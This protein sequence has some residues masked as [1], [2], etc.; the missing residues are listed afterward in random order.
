MSI[1]R[2][3][4]VLVAALGGFAVSAAPITGGSA[5]DDGSVVAIAQSSTVICSGA[6]IAP[7]AVLTAA[8]CL[9]DARLPDVVEGPVPATGVHHRVVGAFVHPDYNPDT[10]DHDLAVVVVEDVL[11]GAPLPYASTLPAAA[12]PGAIVRVVGYGRT[13]ANDPEPPVQHAGTSRIDAV[14]ALRIQSSAAAPHAGGGGAGRRRRDAAHARRSQPRAAPSPGAE[15]DSGGPALIDDGGILRIIGVASTGD[16]AC[17]QFAR[18]TRVDVHAAFVADVVAKTTAGGAAPGDRCWYDANCATGGCVAAIDEPR[19]SFC[20]P[21]CIDGACP[22]GL[23]CSVENGEALCRHPWPSPGADRHACGSNAD[24]ASELCLAAA[25][26]EQ[27]VCTDRCFSDLPGFACPINTECRAAA[28]GTEG[29][30]AIDAGGGCDVAPGRDRGAL[31]VVGLAG[32]VLLLRRR[33]HD[34][35]IDPPD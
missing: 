5:S 33:R 21:A 30:F 34:A 20:S 23:A 2:R 14:D 6:I 16:V 13:V 9:S 8:H 11:A 7:H 28:D 29:C 1:L 17:T 26:E 25:G 35:A 15:G 3:A 22:S 24:C 12:V 4:A 18:H 10:F 27:T 32:F 31:A 19:R